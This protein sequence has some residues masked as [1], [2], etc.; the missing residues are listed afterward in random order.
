[1]M[2]MMIMMMLVMFITT[3]TNYLRTLGSTNN[4]EFAK[5]EISRA[6]SMNS[7]FRN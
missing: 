2:V 1:M 4:M 3:T 6:A 7:V 5:Y